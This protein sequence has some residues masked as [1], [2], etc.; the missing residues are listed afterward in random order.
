MSAVRGGCAWRL[1]VPVCQP[2]VVAVVRAFC[3]C[4]LCVSSVR[5]F[6]AC[7]LCVAA[8]R[9]SAYC[10]VALHRE[11]PAGLAAAGSVFE[12]RNRPY[13][14]TGCTQRHSCAGRPASIFRPVESASTCGQTRI[15]GWSGI[16]LQ[17][18]GQSFCFKVLIMIRDS[19]QRR[20][21]PKRAMAC[22][23]CARLYMQCWHVVS[24]DGKLSSTDS[25][26]FCFTLLSSA[27]AVFFLQNKHSTLN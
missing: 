11:A 12:E 15:F 24:R 14:D 25:L 23:R 5:A 16:G 21:V 9:A 19:L 3:A 13:A 7:L 10:H 1:C 22:L 26:R 20:V 2:S 18:S 4:L 17:A 6:C 8:V 27:F